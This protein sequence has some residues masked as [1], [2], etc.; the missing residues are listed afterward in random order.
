[1]KGDIFPAFS[2]SFL[3]IFGC[4]ETPKPSTPQRTRVL[5]DN[6]RFKFEAAP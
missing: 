3:K 1:M 5:R 4:L 2:V 6:F